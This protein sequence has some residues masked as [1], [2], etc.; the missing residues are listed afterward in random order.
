MQARLRWQQKAKR[1]PPT[2]V[3]SNWT[4]GNFLGGEA[5]NLDSAYIDG[6]ILYFNFTII[7][8]TYTH[9]RMP[10]AD[11]LEIMEPFFVEEMKKY[12]IH[13]EFVKAITAYKKLGDKFTQQIVH[14]QQTVNEN[15]GT[16]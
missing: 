6:G 5:L 2:F 8:E 9:I 12:S 14:I 7:H 15:F 10:F 13:K 11:S 1:A 16:W 3:E 4:T